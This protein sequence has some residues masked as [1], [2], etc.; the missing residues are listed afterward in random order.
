MMVS[1]MVRWNSPLEKTRVSP[2]RLAARRPSTLV[3]EPKAMEGMSVAASMRGFQGVPIVDCGDVDDD[4]RQAQG[5]SRIAEASA[6]VER[7]AMGA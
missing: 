5:G 6:V 3:W 4:E 1:P 2:M 7:A